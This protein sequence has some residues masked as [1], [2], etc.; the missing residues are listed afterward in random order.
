[1]QDAANSKTS[2]VA[3]LNTA[4]AEAKEAAREAENAGNLAKTNEIAAIQAAEV[5]SAARAREI[6]ER[7]AA[8]AAAVDELTKRQS[9]VEEEQAA[10][11]RA[12]SAVE[13]SR[14][15][16]KERDAS[17]AQAREQ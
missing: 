4:V 2:L 1:M 17:A 7:K 3:Q 8:Y 9:L 6:A 11:D 13:S 14:A 15:L 16:G 10:R 5:R 12:A